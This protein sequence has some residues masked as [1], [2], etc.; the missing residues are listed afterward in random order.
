MIDESRQPNRADKAA[1]KA[2]GLP[3]F[4][5]YVQRCYSQ[6]P[7]RNM[8]ASIPDSQPHPLGDF[9]YDSRSSNHRERK[10]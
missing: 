1:S 9:L 10:D 8:A 7:R 3:A 5:Y 4:F 2:S 6:K